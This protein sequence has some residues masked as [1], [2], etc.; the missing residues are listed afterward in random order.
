MSTSLFFVL[1]V[2]PT[3]NDAEAGMLVFVVVLDVVVVVVV[4]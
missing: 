3:E 2:L 1:V 4:G